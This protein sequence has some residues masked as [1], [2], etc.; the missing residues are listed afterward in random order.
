LI[1]GV[2]RAGATGKMIHAE[3]GLGGKSSTEE[4][5]AAEET[6]GFRDEDPTGCD[7]E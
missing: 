4:S 1:R 2:C 6:P 5:A 3:M 7:H